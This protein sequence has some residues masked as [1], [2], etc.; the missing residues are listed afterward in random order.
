MDGEAVVDLEGIPGLALENAGFEI[1]ESARLCA[2]SSTFSA[3][4]TDV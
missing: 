1:E 2:G 4:P 3:L